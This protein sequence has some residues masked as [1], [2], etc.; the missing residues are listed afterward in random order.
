MKK[1]LEATYKRVEK[2]LSDD[3]LMDV[4][5]RSIQ[6]EFMNQYK[7]FDQLIQ[8]CYSTAHLSLEFTADDVLGFF[9]EIAQK[10]N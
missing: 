9:S 3:G 1:G 10:V 2:H 5:W 8:Q 4:V 6:E 7:R